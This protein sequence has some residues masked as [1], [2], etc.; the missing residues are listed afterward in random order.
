MV[1]GWE[2][3]AGDNNGIAEN[4]LAQ[5]KRNQTDALPLA[6]VARLTFLTRNLGQWFQRVLATDGWPA[7]LARRTAPNTGYRQL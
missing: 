2:L 3:K 1:N 4:F 7:N 5:M 6:Y